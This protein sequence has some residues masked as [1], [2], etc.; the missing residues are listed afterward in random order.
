MQ[1]SETWHN[2]P[3][4]LLKYLAGRIGIAIYLGLSS[5][6]GG[7]Q[8][9]DDLREEA[10]EVPPKLRADMNANAMT[11]ESSVLVRIF[12]MESELEEVWKIHSVEDVSNVSVVRK[13]G[14]EDQ[15]WRQASA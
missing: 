1:A 13:I 10:R 14:T 2:R 5:L 15:N 7:T 12:K 6:G 8:T 3:R 4:R 9:L 11:P